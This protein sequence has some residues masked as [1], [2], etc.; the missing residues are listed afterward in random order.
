[1][2]SSSSTALNS[3]LKDWIAPIS[4]N[5]PSTCSSVMVDKNWVIDGEE[6]ENGLQ[7]EGINAELELE[8]QDSPEFG[9]GYSKRSDE[10]DYLANEE[11]VISESVTGLPVGCDNVASGDLGTHVLEPG[12]NAYTITNTVTCTTLTLEKEVIGEA[13]A[14]AWTLAADGPTDLSGATGSAEVTNVP[15]GAG[16]Y[17]IAETGGPENYELTDLSCEGA[18][19]GDG[20]IITIT[21]GSKVTCTFINTQLVDLMV[22]KTWVVNGTEYAHGEQPVGDAELSIDGQTAEFGE[23]NAGHRIGDEVSIAET[24]TGTLPEL[25][26]PT[27]ST[28]DGVE[29]T[30]ATHTMTATTLPNVVEI[31]NTVNCEQQ[32]TLVKVVDNE[33][34]NGTS[35]RDDWTLTATGTEQTITGTTEEISITDASVAVGTYQLSEDDT[36]AGYEPG[37]WSCDGTGTADGASIT[38]DLGQ[39][40]T[41]TIV[42]TALPGSVTW[43]KTNM[44]GELLA[45]AEW[46][47]TGPLGEDSPAIAVTDCIA[48]GCAGPDMDPAKGQFALPDLKWGSYTLQETTAPPGYIKDGTVREFEVTGEALE[49]ELV[50][51]ENEQ[52]AGP[53]LPLTGGIGR[54]Q[55]YL[56]GGGILVLGLSILG[57]QTLRT[58]RS[59]SQG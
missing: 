15:V 4:L 38:L 29:T 44:S 24:I 41:C 13:A 43:T 47:L 37:T 22:N 23:I 36:V 9:T 35:T 26:E 2:R 50:A 3:S 56:L 19:V 34:F 58:R 32:L 48:E 55:I 57:L 10:T 28:I 5:V 49:V 18:V 52:Q 42:N 45:G 16:D 14:T 51:F 11:V 12:V 31:V 21:A 40:A 7:P 33:I 39:E 25:C 8:G 6:F 59:R 27:S 54:D 20:N 17:A 46:I 53:E 30:S 1:M